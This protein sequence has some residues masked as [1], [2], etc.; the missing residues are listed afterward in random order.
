MAK[1]EFEPFRLVDDVGI[2]IS[3]CLGGVAVMDIVMDNDVKAVMEFMQRTVPTA[4]LA[5]VAKA[6][7]N[8]APIF[9]GEHQKEGV[10]ALF[11]REPAPTNDARDR[12]TLR[13]ASE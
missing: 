10:P 8:L 3:Q 12:R 1:L 11:L 2:G 7:C 5:G 9:W 4:R 13:G 6:I